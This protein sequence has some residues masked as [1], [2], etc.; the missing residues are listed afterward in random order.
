VHKA[1]DPPLFFIFTALARHVAH[2]PFDGQGML[3]QAL[4]LVEFLKER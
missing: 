2:Y 3:D 4:S 1:D